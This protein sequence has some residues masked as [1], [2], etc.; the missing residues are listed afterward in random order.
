METVTGIAPDR[1]ATRRVFSLR[2]RARAYLALSKPRIIELLLTAT[3]PTMILAARGM[4][5]LPLVCITVIG[6]FFSA[7]SA[8]AFN[9]YIDRDIDRVMRRTEHRPLVTGELT[10]SE[11]LGFAWLTGITSIAA[12]AVLVNWLAAFLTAFAIFYYVVV[13]TMWL[14]RR[15]PQNIVWGGVAGCMPVLIGWAA[16]TDG[17]SWSA[18]CLFLVIFLWTPPHYWPLAVKYREDYE[19]AEVPMLPVLRGGK[20]V[21]TQIIL[22]AWAMVVC[23]LLLIPL[24]PMGVLYAIAAAG[25]G[26]W[27]I[28]QTHRLFAE[29]LGGDTRRAMRVFHGSIWYLS[30]LFVA[31]A[32]DPFIYVPLPTIMTL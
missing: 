12:F 27:F 26:G 5:S 28:W 10:D 25:A 19:R 4:P 24:A 2:D 17:L 15:T 14:K 20:T 7:A 6:G 30:V 13:Y 1:T 29:T 18:L 9:C 22:Y 16:V 8:N 11:A 3:V 32:L 31:V 23:S 21:G